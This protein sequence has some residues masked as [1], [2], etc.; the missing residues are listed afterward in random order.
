[1]FEV[2]G[3][4]LSWLNFTSRP[5]GGSVKCFSRSGRS[6]RNVSLSVYLKQMG[7]FNWTGIWNVARAVRMRV[8]TSE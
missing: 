1:M 3:N 6:M 7:G 8:E 5:E 2:T 4:E